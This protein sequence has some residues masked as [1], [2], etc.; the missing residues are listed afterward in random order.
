LKGADTV[1]ESYDGSFDF[2]GGSL[3]ADPNDV[4]LDPAFD[5][6]D[7]Q[8]LVRDPDSEDDADSLGDWEE[9]EEY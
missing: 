9:E 2:V 1:R 3:N 4:T 8:D 6:E 7:L 5:P